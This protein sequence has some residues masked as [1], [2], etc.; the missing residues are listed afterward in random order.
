MKRRAV[1]VDGGLQ[2]SFSVKNGC[3]IGR[4]PDWHEFQNQLSHS[5]FAFANCS[6]DI[7]S[8]SENDFCH[9]VCLHACLGPVDVGS[10][11]Q[12]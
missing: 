1:P 4:H 7:L 5:T 2:Y 3:E 11:F 6:I 9:R 8:K 10:R 12:I